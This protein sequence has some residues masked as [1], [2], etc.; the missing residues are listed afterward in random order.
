M[1]QDLPWA[2]KDDAL[3]S[4]LERW[5]QAQGIQ[6]FRV[7]ESGR[8][9]QTVV[10]AQENPL[11]LSVNVNEVVTITDNVEIEVFR[12][13]SILLQAAVI[14]LG[15]QDEEGH[16]IRILEPA[17]RA[18]VEE[19]ERDPNFMEKLS[20]RKWEEIIA[21][22][23][24]K[25]GFRD[26]HL[27]PQSGDGGKDVVATMP[28]QITV[29]IIDQVKKYKPGHKVPANDIRALLGVLHDPRYTKGLVTTTSHFA[30]GILTD[31]SIKHLIPAKLELRDREQILTWLSTLK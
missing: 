12:P 11:E 21:A 24:V 4:L 10:F 22:A 28:G 20:W 19:I 13:P 23:Y 7:S 6:Q 1:I 25:A 29:R 17:W 14:E 31:P 2:S 26:V 8:G 27:T 5:K 30:P 15:K 3:P 9:A 16:L 18:I